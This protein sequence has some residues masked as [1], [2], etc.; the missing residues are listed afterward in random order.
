MQSF[1]LEQ[2]QLVMTQDRSE[3]LFLTLVEALEGVHILGWLESKRLVLKVVSG[4]VKT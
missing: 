3:P 4:V 2:Q 1:D